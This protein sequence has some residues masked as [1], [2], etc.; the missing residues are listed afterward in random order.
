ML[1]HVFSPCVRRASLALG[2]TLALLWVL[3]RPLFSTHV[4]QA[5]SIESARQLS[6]MQ[7]VA[8]YV[9]PPPLGNDANDCASVATPCATIQHAIDVANDGDQVFIASGFYTQSATLAK[10]VSLIGADCDTTIIH[11]VE[12]QRV[13][14]VT[15]A[16]ISNSVVISGLTLTGADIASYPSCPE[17]CGGGIYI[18]DGAQPKLTHLNLTHNHAVLGGGVFIYNGQLDLSYANFIDN[19]AAMDGGGVS[20][21]GTAQIAGSRFENNRALGDS[22]GGFD[23]GGGSTVLTD[24]V[25]TGNFA[26]REGGGMAVSGPATI[27]NSV[28]ESNNAFYGGGIVAYDALEITHTRFISNHADGWGGGIL[29]YGLLKGEDSSF[30][31]NTV[32]GYGGGVNSFGS[33][34]LTH[35]VFI[36]NR[37]TLTTC[38]GG[39]L[40]LS[41]GSDNQIELDNMLFAKNAALYQGAA[42]YLE[43]PCLRCTPS[44]LR[45]THTTISSPT[46]SGI[47]GIYVE[48]GTGSILNSIL[49]SHTIA[50]SN[51]G[52]TITEDYNLFF[53]NTT[54]MV[55]VTTGTHSLNGD[56]R[57]IDPL[58]DDYHLQFGSPAIDHG[59]DAGV[60]TDL[61]GN[62]RPIGVGFDIGAYEYQF[63]PRTIIYLPVITR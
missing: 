26:Y 24:V 47:S 5:Q 16:T 63:V 30:V 56:P 48:A 57:F 10:P 40:L 27:A 28:F 1:H 20:M 35:S 42:I 61:D 38:V 3:G 58:H 34:S 45:V 54:N 19:T 51:T 9:A 36:G 32:G 62:P 23:I 18:I 8:W 2:L 37:C 14:T 33:V 29:V 50:I 60:Y 4:V 59:V 52:G 21:F 13:L 11:A 22:G 7:A 43:G 55:G 12:G 39:G 49:S 6:A 46:L 41:S 31:R 25:M 44:H 17:G 53:D 15:G